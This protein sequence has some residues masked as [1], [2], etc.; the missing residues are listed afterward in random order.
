LP[1]FIPA[2]CL[3][4]APAR[5]AQW[6]PEVRLT[7]NS[8]ADFSYWSCQRR[9]AVDQQGRIHV[10]WHVMNSGLGTYR[11]QVYYTRCNPGSGWTQD[12]MLSA[13]LYAA[14]TYCKY[15]SVGVDSAGRVYV[16]WAGGTTE[17]ADEVVYLKTCVPEGSGNGGW[18]ATSR[19]LST[20]GT[21]YEKGCPTITAT[22]DGHAHATWLEV[23][24]GGGSYISYRERIDTTWQDETHLEAS[25]NYKAYPAVAGGPDNRV[26]VIWYGRTSPSG[27]YNV[28]YKGRTGTTWGATEN[29]S[30][31][32]RHQ[33]YPSIAA[34]P[35]TGNPH[36]FWQC[37]TATGN[38]RKAVHS[39]RTGAGWQPTDTL[40]E[41]TDTLNQETGQVVFTADG[42][43]H[44]LWSG[45]IPSPSA[46]IQIRYSERSVSGGWSGPFNV[47][48]AASAKER[49]SIAT[50][51]GTA[52]NDIH[53]VWCDYRDGNAEIYYCHARPDSVGAEEHL[54]QDASRPVPGATIVRGVLRLPASNNPC[55]TQAFFDISGREVLDLHPGGYDVSRLSPG[56]YF[57]RGVGAGGTGRVVVAE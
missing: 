24:T 9:V 50:G 35:V 8:Y 55:L 7:N 48:S 3:L 47:T 44:V 10:V 36:V 14:S 11:F 30:N 4:A 5:G 38:Y 54:R 21:D 31:G 53:A 25:T 46:P 1:A 33:M 19:A 27:F 51:S 56:V 17:D 2:L 42:I 57:L 23:G 22:P 45:R 13:D 20:T 26:H 29:V 40:S 49:P 41:T 28:F 15:P 12:T 32:E 34:N 43:G 6:D 52:P 39:Y 18:D 16:V 37:Y